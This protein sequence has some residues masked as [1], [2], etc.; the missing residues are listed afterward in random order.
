MRR[1][2]GHQILGGGFG[3]CLFRKVVFGRGD[4]VRDRYRRWVV[5][6]MG[7]RHGRRKQKH[8]HGGRRSYNARKSLLHSHAA[9]LLRIGGSDEMYSRYK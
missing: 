4:V 3:C 1:R 8:D 9:N 5:A 7:G 2:N 6:G